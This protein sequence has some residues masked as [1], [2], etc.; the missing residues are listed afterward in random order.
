MYE[1]IER[2][3]IEKGIKISKL[4][5]DAQ[6]PRSTFT[7]LKSGR[8]KKLSTDTLNKVAK[9]FDVSVDYLLGK[10]EKE[11]PVTEDELNSELLLE[12][13]SLSNE[14]QEKLLT[15]MKNREKLQAL[16]SL[17]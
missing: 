12:F 16:L 3:C 10:E 6:I 4:S 17:L 11:K 2:L 15:I 13:L 5:Q 14:E 1:I 9:Y 8:T 7:E